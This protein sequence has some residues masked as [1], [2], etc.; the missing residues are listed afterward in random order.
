LA[1][2]LARR[3]YG[4][5]IPFDDMYQVACVALVRAARGYDA[6]RGTDFIAYAVPSISG[7]IRKHFRDC[8]WTVRP[9]RRI[10][11]MQARVSKEEELLTQERDR[12]PTEDEIAESLGV[13]VAEVHESR[14]ALGCFTPSSL[15]AE[16]DGAR[17]LV[18]R[19]G[20]EEH[21]YDECEARLVVRDALD[22]L[23]SRDRKIVELRFF[24]GLTQEQIGS[25]IGVSQMQVSRLLSR[26][27]RDLRTRL[28]ADAA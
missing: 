27:F 28:G 25:M 17:S 12:P 20:E 7:E 3:Y 14:S 2:S 22:T 10:Q 6:D 23:G 9:P 24:E 19:L 18:Q 5:G 1:R 16:P 11:E 4:R 13:P 21:G 8:G 26:I 15:D